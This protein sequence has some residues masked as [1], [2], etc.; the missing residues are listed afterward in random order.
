MVFSCSTASYDVFN[1]ATRWPH[2]LWDYK[3]EIKMEENDCAQIVVFPGPDPTPNENTRRFVN[4]AS[5][6]AFQ[7]SRNYVLRRYLFF[8]FFGL[9][10]HFQWLWMKDHLILWLIS[11][12]EHIPR[13]R[14]EKITCG[15]R[16][17]N[18]YYIFIDSV[19]DIFFDLKTKRK[20]KTPKL[21]QAFFVPSNIHT[22]VHRGWKVFFLVVFSKWMWTGTDR[23][24]LAIVGHARNVLV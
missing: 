13:I 5:R 2:V 17:S 24:S 4:R 8:F 21:F 22:A 9:S 3:E 19:T 14:R 6:I 7:S 18:D 1:C 15:L 10:T 16:S 11:V 23:K 12:G 20:N